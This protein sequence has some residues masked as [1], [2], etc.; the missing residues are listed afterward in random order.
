MRFR[1]RQQDVLIVHLCWKNKDLLPYIYNIEGYGEKSVTNMLNAIE[2][3][4]NNSLEKLLFGLGMRH[5]GKKAAKILSENFDDIYEIV[6]ASVEEINA[7]DD[8]GEIMAKSV[9]DFFS[10]EQTKKLIQKLENAGVNLK[11]NKKELSS[12][13]LKDKIF[14]VTGSF[15]DYSRNDIT[16]LIEENSGKVSGSVSKKTSFLVAGENAGSKLSKAESLGIPVI[17]IEKLKEMIKEN[18]DG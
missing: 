7:L 6:K 18:I 12:N 1:L 2:E 14:V 10:K 11:G 4:K 5:I 17:S 9:V 13:K 3:S 16:K 8:F 15:D